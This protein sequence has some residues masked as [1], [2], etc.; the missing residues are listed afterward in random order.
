MEISLGNIF[1]RPNWLMHKGDKVNGHVHNFDHMTQCI[2][3][4][5]EIRRGDNG[6]ITTLYPGPQNYELIEAGVSHE[7]T[8][9]ED[10]THFQC[11]YAHR[12]PQGD[13]VQQHTGWWKAYT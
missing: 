3:G 1:I 2:S 4:A 13:V 10:N 12:T 6:K 9:L 5:I 7:I 11:I 8:A